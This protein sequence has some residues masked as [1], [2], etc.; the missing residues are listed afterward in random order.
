MI[1][2][3]TR[4]FFSQL[5][6]VSMDSSRHSMLDNCCAML[7]SMA[8]NA[9]SN[10]SIMCRIKTQYALFQPHYRPL[11]KKLKRERGGG[12]EVVAISL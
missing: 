7:P 5:T 8:V 4:H 2:I 6:T 12:N 1:H 9:F 11:E 3:V 10:L